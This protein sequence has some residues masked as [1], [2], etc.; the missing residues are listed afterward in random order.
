MLA[1][2]TRAFPFARRFRIPFASLPLIVAARRR[3]RAGE[4]VST[5][6]V[7]RAVRRSPSSAHRDPWGL[8]QSRP[9]STFTVTHAFRSR[10]RIADDQGEHRREFRLI[11]ESPDGACTNPVPNP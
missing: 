10:H 6:R 4:T 7:P 2:A 9:P 8:P 5:S 11:G 1:R 3:R